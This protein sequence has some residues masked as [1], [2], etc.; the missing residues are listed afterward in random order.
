MHSIIQMLPFVLHA[1]LA[2]AD[3]TTPGRSDRMFYKCASQDLGMWEPQ[4]KGREAAC[5]NAYFCI[6]CMVGYSCLRSCAE[7]QRTKDL[8]RH[9]TLPMLTRS[10][11][12]VLTVI[13]K[14]NKN[15][16]ES[17]CR[18]DKPQG[19]S[20]CGAFPFSQMFSDKLEREPDCGGWP[21]ASAIQ[22]PFNTPGQILNSLRCMTPFE[23]RTLGSVLSGFL[24]SKHTDRDDF[25]H[26]DFTKNIASAD[27]SK[28]QYCLPRLDYGQDGRQFQLSEKPNVGGKI[29]SPYDGA[30]GKDKKY[31]LAD[32][33][34]KELY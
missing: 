30:K 28:V 5:N 15:C 16:H 20:V 25:F 34:Y 33:A 22:D 1:A 27:Q 11:M 3:G 18:A 31:K 17:G 7:F 10:H 19:T 12:F 4:C 14:K 32:V 29:D 2:T 9:A 26:L 8:N 13:V 23:N 21:P 6:R 24:Q